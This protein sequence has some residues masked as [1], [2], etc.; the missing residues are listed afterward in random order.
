MSQPEVDVTAVP[1]DRGDESDLVFAVTVDVRPEIVIPDPAGITLTVHSVAVTDE[2]T[3]ER[4][5]SLRE[6]FGTL[7]DV[8]R[9][10]ADGDFV[11]IDI[12]LLRLTVKRSIRFPAFL[13][14]SAPARC[15]T[16]L[17]RHSLAFLLA[18]PPNSHLEDRRWRARGRRWRCDCDCRSGSGAGASRS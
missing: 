2:D 16:A 8:E 5:T 12:I 11:T 9:A 18:K 6:R 10:A 15:W 4:L 3:E 13:T 14:R 1:V 7:K 17:M